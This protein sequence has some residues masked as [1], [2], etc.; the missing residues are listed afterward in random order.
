MLSSYTE[1]YVQF[2]HS[3]KFAL[4]TVNILLAMSVTCKRSNAKRSVRDDFAFLRGHEIFRP[5]FMKLCT[6]DRVGEAT[7]LAKKKAY[8][9]LVR[10]GSRIG[11]GR[12][13]HT[14]KL[15]TANLLVFEIILHAF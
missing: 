2:Q 5:I 1:L 15:Q 7:K 8:N 9:R 14:Q 6:F 12:P 10:C 13:N 11:A 4:Q 3:S